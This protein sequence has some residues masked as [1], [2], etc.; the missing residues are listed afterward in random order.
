[1]QLKSRG[2]VV[3]S[4]KY[5]ESS[6]IVK[7]F[8]E[9]S[10]MLSFMVNGVRSSRA[11]TTAS[12]FEPLNILELTYT[13]REN[14]SLQRFSDIRLQQLFTGL[15]TEE[16]RAFMGWL[17]AEL[18]MKCIREHE[19]NADLF[20]FIESSI[21]QLDRDAYV[22]E[23]H[24]LFMIKLCGLL[25]FELQ[26]N[27]NELNNRFNLEEGQFTTAYSGSS[28]LLN[29]TESKL[30]F[31]LLQSTGEVGQPKLQN[32]MER[33]LALDALVRYYQ[34]HV[35]GFLSLKSPAILSGMMD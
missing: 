10:G 34:F 32:R 17:M 7:I 15:R 18:L 27:Y 26:G 8:T 19:P 3:H 31:Q 6:L 22:P 14:K 12:L 1:M 5:G 16:R 13:F 25:G 23:F 21:L 4:T 33:N 11:K 35:E 20:E 28:N 9:T 30:I 29:E 24:L 2:I